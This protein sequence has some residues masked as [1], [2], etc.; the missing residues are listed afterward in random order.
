M[1]SE[2]AARLRRAI[3]QRGWTIRTLASK[4]GVPDEVLWDFS[5]GRSWPDEEVIG[6][7]AQT[8]HMH[9]HDLSPPARPR[10]ESTRKRRSRSSPPRDSLGLSVLSGD[11]AEAVR[12][13]PSAWR[14]KELRRIERRQDALVRLLMAA[15]VFTQQE[16]EGKLTAIIRRRK[17]KRGRAQP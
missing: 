15:G 5:Q 8:L 17:E 7:I 12:G 14:L 4:A 1:L 3:E 2:V 10:R 6:R 11:A 9:R 13:A 16:W